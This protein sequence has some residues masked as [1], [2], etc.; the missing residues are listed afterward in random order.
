MLYTCI[1][2]QKFHIF[3]EEFRKQYETIRLIDLSKT[4]THLLAD[5][6]DAIVVHHKECC[7]FLGYIEPGWML[8]PCHQTRIR[9]LFRKF[10][11]GIVLQ[12]PESIP[13]SW[14]NE[15]DIVYTFNDLKKNGETNSINNG[16]S[17]HDKSKI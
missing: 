7:I 10:P 1:N 9:K 6:C 16:S 3:F 8:E 17:I 12:F 5:E 14:K 15:I 11:V 13:F 4:P 2:I